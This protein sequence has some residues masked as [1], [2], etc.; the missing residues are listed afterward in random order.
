VR[1]NLTV[2]SDLK[3]ALTS[4]NLLLRVGRLQPVNFISIVAASR[5]KAV[6][7]LAASTYSTGIGDA[8]VS[9][10][11]VLTNRIG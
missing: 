5:H 11:M 2:C 8:E 10:W 4:V 9:E 7:E 6:V 1:G 3:Q